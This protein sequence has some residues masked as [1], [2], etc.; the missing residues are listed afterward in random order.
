MSKSNMKNS[1]QK[2]IRKIPIR[3]EYPVEKVLD[4]KKHGSEIEYLVK[5]EGFDD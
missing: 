1:Q 3:E 2:S 5:W 4:M